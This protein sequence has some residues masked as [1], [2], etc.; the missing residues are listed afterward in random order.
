MKIVSSYKVQI[1]C[2][3]SSLRDARRLY[4]SA[5]YFLM[6]VFHS[7]WSALQNIKNAKE[8]FNAAEHLI[9]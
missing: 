6:G 7:E 2:E 3:N 4:R 8:R 1:F 5:L 9:H